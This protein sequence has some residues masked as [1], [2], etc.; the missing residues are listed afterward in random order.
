MRLPQAAIGAQCF[1]LDGDQEILSEIIAVAPRHIDV[2]EKGKVDD[3]GKVIRH[4]VKVGLHD[5]L[6]NISSLDRVSD[7]KEEEEHAAL[8]QQAYRRASTTRAANPF[9]DPSHG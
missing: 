9:E 8:R 5:V 3:D 6:P 2:E 7:R 1:Y 4:R